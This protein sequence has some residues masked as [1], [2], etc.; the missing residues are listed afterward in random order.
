[1]NARAAS[2]RMLKGTRAGCQWAAQPHWTSALRR[3]CDRPPFVSIGS[4]A[5][6]RSLPDCLPQARALA[7]EKAVTPW[8]TTSAPPRN[9][10]ATRTGGQRRKVAVGFEVRRTDYENW[11]CLKGDRGGRPVVARTY[12]NVVY[13]AGQREQQDPQLRHKPAL[14]PA[15]RRTKRPAWH[16]ATGYRRAARTRSSPDSIGEGRRDKSACSCSAAMPRSRNST[17]EQPGI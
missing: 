8:D 5:T 3:K 9:C 15:E 2:L 6:V 16:A 4:T 1:M 12:A 17:A 11:G 7:I 10:L 14:P 13:L